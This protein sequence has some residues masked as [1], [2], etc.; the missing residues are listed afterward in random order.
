MKKT[1]PFKH[2]LT[3][4]ELFFLRKTLPLIQVQGDVNFWYHMMKVVDNLTKEEEGMINKE[5]M[6]VVHANIVCYLLANGYLKKHVYETDEYISDQKAKE[7]YRTLKGTKFTGYYTLT[8]LGRELRF[9]AIN[10]TP[11]SFKEKYI[12]LVIDWELILD[13]VIAFYNKYLKRKRKESVE[14]I[15]EMFKINSVRYGDLEGNLHLGK[16]EKK[17]L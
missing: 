5:N 6:A 4:L 9:A 14:D 17:N 11:E 3:K 12:R 16:S 8:D 13:K 10:D 15:E 2:T 7:G 1:A